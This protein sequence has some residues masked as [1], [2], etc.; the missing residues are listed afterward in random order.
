MA[1]L[2]RPVA[3]CSYRSEIC[4]P[5]VV[6]FAAGKEGIYPLTGE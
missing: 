6:A 2:H 4:V 5:A 1:F 3:E